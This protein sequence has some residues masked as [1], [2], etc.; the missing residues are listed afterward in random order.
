MLALDRITFDAKIH[1]AP[2]GRDIAVAS[3]APRAFA[4]G[5]ATK[6]LRGYGRSRFTSYLE[7]CRLVVDG[8][9]GT[10]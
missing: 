7:N 9:S 1:V 8:A 2:S 6:P 4:H 5:F 3:L 10:G